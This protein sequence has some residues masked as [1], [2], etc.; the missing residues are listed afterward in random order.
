MYIIIEELSEGGVRGVRKLLAM[1]CLIC[2]LPVCA[3][4]VPDTPY[5]AG[6]MLR[7]QLLSTK[8]KM[9]FDLLYTAAARGDNTVKLP[10][11][12]AYQDA[13]IVMDALTDDCPELCALS[14][15]YSI[16][17][18][19]DEPDCAVEVKLQYQ[20]PQETQHMLLDAA[21]A[22]AEQAQGDAYT[23]EVQ[24]HD[25]LCAA[26]TYDLTGQA[27]AT[28]YGA[29]VEGRAGCEGYARAMIL[30]CRLAGIP[31]GLVT[32]T[33]L[34]NGQMERHAWCVMSVGGVMTQTDPTW[35]DQEGLG[36]NTYWY[37]NLTDAQMAA[38]HQ[39]D[40]GLMLPACTDA[41]ASWHA[42]NGWLVPHEGGEE[43]IRRALAHFAKENT[44]VSLRF[45][46]AEDAAAFVDALDQWW[47]N[48]NEENPEYPFSGSYGAAVSV[49]QGCVLILPAS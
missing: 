23:R 29:L 14:P 6:L 34:H 27:Q 44:A 46:C 18:Y 42:R 35:N 36:V 16:S 5:D 40:E 22:L 49:T 28:A 17:Y 15:I 30:L 4:A 31:S 7:Y 25:A 19:R 21:L 43:V 12:T 8:Q 33:A 13:V 10:E 41:S 37:F 32:G 20:L 39:P 47:H 1:I 11:K 9:L 45:A 26:A 48:Y 38:D 24:L 2:M 3:S